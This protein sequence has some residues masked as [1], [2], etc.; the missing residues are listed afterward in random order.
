[1]A[2]RELMDVRPTGLA[3][4]EEPPEAVEGDPEKPTAEEQR[5]YN[6]FVMRAI[7]FIHGE[8]TQNKV[9]AMMNHPD[10]PVHVNVGRAAS[11]IVQLIQ[12]SAESSGQRLPDSVVYSAGQEIIT[13]L[14]E[15]GVEAKIF[16]LEIDSKEYDQTLDLSFLEAVK[17]YGEDLLKGPDGEQVSREAQDA[18]SREVAREA[19]AGEIDSDLAETFQQQVNPEYA[20]MNAVSEGVHRAV[21]DVE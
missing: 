11:R 19:D 14:L 18:Y 8:Q 3:P 7:N 2:E 6:R 1:M 5:L 12:Q 9:L 17:A 13:E 20:Q 15:T 16:P 10:Q 21:N 4:G